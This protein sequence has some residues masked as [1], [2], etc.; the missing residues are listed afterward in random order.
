MQYLD[1]PLIKAAIVGIMFAAFY[2]FAKIK[3]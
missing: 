3:E 2:I 1:G